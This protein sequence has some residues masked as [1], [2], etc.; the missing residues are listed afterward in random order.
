MSD[1]IP[2]LSADD[3]VNDHSGSVDARADGIGQDTHVDH[4]QGC[5]QNSCAVAQSSESGDCGLETNESGGSLGIGG[6]SHRGNVRGCGQTG[7]QLQQGYIIV[8]V[9][10]VVRRIHD[11]VVGCQLDEW[12]VEIVG[13]GTDQEGGVALDAVGSSENPVCG[14]QSSSAGNGGSSDCAADPHMPRQLSNCS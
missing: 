3:V 12:G 7:G 14:D 6:Q 13:S 11:P 2:S 9:G 5:G 1:Q 10:W 8:V 4:L